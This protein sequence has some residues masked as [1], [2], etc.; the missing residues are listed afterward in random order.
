LAWGNKRRAPEGASVVL[1]DR[2]TGAAVDPVLTDPGDPERSP[3]A[4]E[5]AGIA[6]LNRSR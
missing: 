3:G 6:A 4:W 1:N 2:R 5:N